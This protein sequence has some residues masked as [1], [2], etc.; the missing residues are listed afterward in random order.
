MACAPASMSRIVPHRRPTSQKPLLLSMREQVMDRKLLEYNPETE[1]F[2]AGAIQRGDSEWSGAASA[3]ETFDEAGEME[4]A[5]GL[6]EVTSEAELDR[7]LGALVERAGRVAGSVAGSPTA[8]ALAGILKGAAEQ[9]LPMIGR[10]IGHRLGDAGG[11]RFDVVQ[12][13][14]KY[15]GLEL[16][17]L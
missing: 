4:F 13:A 15:F 9:A 5:A 6:L 7:F 2:E 17:G 12:A 14:G 1:A 11:T 16:Q 8:R 3:G 10:A